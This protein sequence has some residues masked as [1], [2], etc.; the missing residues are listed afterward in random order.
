MSEVN[1]MN[2]LDWK[3]ENA[4][5]DELED[6]KSYTGYLRTEKVKADEWTFD[7]ERDLRTSFLQKAVADGHVAADDSEAQKALFTQPEYSAPRSLALM[8]QIGSGRLTAIAANNRDALP[9]GVEPEDVWND[10]VTYNAKQNAYNQIA[11]EDPDRAAQAT[12]LIEDLNFWKERA[13]GY[14]NSPK[15]LARATESALQSGE[16][17]S[18][19]DYTRKMALP[20]FVLVEAHKWENHATNS[21]MSQKT[22]GVTPRGHSSVL[23]INYSNQLVA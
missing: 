23:A 18:R 8:E 14:A 15:S 17:P 21:W 19:S 9:E 12:D 5:G 10:I 7:F 1:V 22:Y 11:A 4:S 20:K 6:L 3:A 16:D 2:F 13:E